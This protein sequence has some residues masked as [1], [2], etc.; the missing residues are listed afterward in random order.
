M[1][2]SSR[3]FYGGRQCRLV[4]VTD[5]SLK[6]ESVPN[7]IPVETGSDT[8]DHLWPKGL[9]ASDLQKAAEQSQIYQKI[10][11]GEQEDFNKQ[12]TKRHQLRK[13]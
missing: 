5:S 6:P 3:L 10:L 4:L 8:C 12:K 9:Y 2:V 7:R 1:Y 11:P 13:R